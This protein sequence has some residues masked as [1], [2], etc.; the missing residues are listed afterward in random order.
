M[1]ECI[2]G[3]AKEK[4]VMAK[5]AR[6]KPRGETT[7]VLE[8]N[9]G[10]HRQKQFRRIKAM[11]TEHGYKQPRLY[12]LILMDDTETAERQGAARFLKALKVLCLELRQNGIP[13]RWRACLERDEKKGMHFHVYVLVDAAKQ[14]P[15]AYINK[16][17]GK[18]AWLR[19]MLEK[20]AL[21]FYLSPPKADMHRVG[22]TAEGKRKNY[23]SLAGDKLDDCIQWISYLAKARSKPDGVRNIY[24]SSRDSLYAPRTRPAEASPLTDEETA[25]VAA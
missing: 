19:N 17:T 14:N 3:A 25:L 8:R 12:H 6:K 21:R 18:E 24:F 16:K 1:G 4:E 20:R 5:A 9:G 22:G 23:A 11:L 2:N 15:C 7:P 10:M 13:T